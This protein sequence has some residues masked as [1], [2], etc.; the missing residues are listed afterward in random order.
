MSPRLVGAV[1]LTLALCAPPALAQD[2]DAELEDLLGLDLEALMSVEVVSASRRAQSRGEAPANV[3]VVTR[4]QIRRRGYRSLHELLMDIPHVDVATGQPAGEYPTHFLF[5]GAGDVGQSKVLVMVDNVVRND[6]SNGWV[7]LIGFESHMNDIERV[8]IIS[9]PGSVFFGANAYAGVIHVITRNGN[10][11]LDGDERI[12]ADARV[13]FGSWATLVPEVNLTARVAEDLILTASGRW[14]TSRGDRGA[15]RADPGGYWTGN[16]EPFT[17]FTNEF[18][19]IPNDLGPNGEPKKLEDGYDNSVD[20]YSLRTRLHYK[21]LTIGVDGWD[22]FEGLGTEVVG[23]EYFANTKGIPYKAH[24]RGLT[25]FAHQPMK[26]SD[27]ADA[28]ARMYMR[29]TQILPQTAFVYTFQHQSV[30]LGTSIQLPDKPKRYLGEGS[31]Y[32]T[33]GLLHLH[34]MDEEKATNTLTLGFIGEHLIRQYFAISLGPGLQVGSSVNPSTW[35]DETTTINPTYFT[36]RGGVF[37]NDEQRIGKQQLTAGIRIDGDQLYGLAVNPRAAM[38]LNPHE[39]VRFKLLY[40]QAYKAPTIFELYDEWRGNEALAPE[41][42]WTVEPMIELRPVEDLALTA[43]FF[44]SDSVDLITVAPNRNPDEVPI[45]PQGQ[46]ANYYQNRGRIHFNGATLMIDAVVA[47]AVS[48]HANYAFLT[49]EDGPVDNTSPHKA[50]AIVNVDTWGKADL[51]FRV[52]WA[53]K[54]KAPES[55]LYWQPRNAAFIQDNYDYV[56]ANGANGYG[57]GHF[58]AHVMITG[59]DLFP[60]EH[61]IRPQLGVLNLFDTKWLAMGRQSGSGVK[62]IDQPSVA[63]PVGFSPAYHPQPGREVWFQLQYEF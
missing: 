29:R 48:L 46:R 18:G 15:G 28:E 38:I 21:D 54:V 40:G 24:H 37:I 23:Y 57:P 6:I 53:S 7:R 50:N 1:T 2:G 25:V 55:N 56:R 34:L 44:H 19:T 58:L 42:I 11:V 45:G 16:R 52:N 3:L 49:A 31:Q 39:K 5:R 32:G 27:R 30:D 41:R 20:D 12:H 43:A 10:D 33:E 61:Q 59:K 13:A 9:G 8:E 17:V 47:D 63:N 26:L 35:P 62:P 22:R 4:E 51:N 60:G 14:F 36:N